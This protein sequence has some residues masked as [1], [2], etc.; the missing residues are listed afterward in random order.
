MAAPRFNQ[1]N[2]VVA[3][4]DASLAFYRLLGLDVTGGDPWPAGSQARHAE[5]AAISPDGASL[6]LDNGASLAT[7]A[8]DWDDPGGV[9]IGVSVPSAADV[10]ELH[11]RAVAAGYGSRRAPAD[12]YWGARYAIVVDPDGNS[13]GLMGPIAKDKRLSHEAP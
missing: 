7:W 13:V 6:E 8:P 2:V 1:V 9:V 3:D 5:A 4:M 12:A 10:D 11:H